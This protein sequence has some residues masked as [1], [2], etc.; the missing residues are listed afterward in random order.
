[1]A[2]QLFQAKLLTATCLPRHAP[3]VCCPHLSSCDYLCRPIWNDLSSYNW[4]GYLMRLTHCW[5]DNIH[6]FLSCKMIIYLYFRYFLKSKGIKSSSHLEEGSS[7]LP[8]ALFNYTHL[9]LAPSSTTHVL[10]LF[11]NRRCLR[12]LVQTRA[13]RKHTPRSLPA[14]TA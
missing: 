11:Q 2:C 7:E 3:P 9:P 8:K 10:K 6:K 5:F 12:R 1:M 13:F 14:W 4:L